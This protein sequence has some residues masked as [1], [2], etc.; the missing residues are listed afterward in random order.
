M[1]SVHKSMN[2]QYP[3]SNP[4]LSL[5]D[6]RSEAEF[7]RGH[8]PGAINV[9]ILNNE[10][11]KQV[12][13]CYKHNGSEKAIHLGYALVG[14]KFDDKLKQV[15]HSI[16]GNKAIIYCWRGGLRSKIFSEVLEEGGLEIKRLAD[17]YK[18][19]RNC[20]L[21]QL[22]LPIP[23]V[24]LG[25]ATGTG[26]TEL[27]FS[28]QDLGEQI[29]N[30]EGLANH[31]GSAYGGIEMPKQPSNEQFENELAVKLY[32]FKK[33][34][35]IWIENESRHLGKVKIPD[36]FFSQMRKGKSTRNR[37]TSFSTRTTN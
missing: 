29:I 2:I 34:R 8:I 27:L 7:T 15:K 24:V 9:P 5:I 13:I 10:E 25:G 19:F 37:K 18:Y 4:N 17:G 28:L 22:E 16:H 36:C 1:L 33:D 26:K 35:P 21:N 23:L 12:G 31:K 20:V 6:V 11:R 30:L 14:H 32:H 3:L